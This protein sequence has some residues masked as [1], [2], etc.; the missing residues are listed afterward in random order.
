M[1]PSL[2]WVWS[3]LPPQALD[4]LSRDITP[5]VSLGHAHYH[6]NLC[7]LCYSDEGTS[8]TCRTVCSYKVDAVHVGPIYIPQ[9]QSGMF[10]HIS[11][12]PRSLLTPTFQG[13][14]SVAL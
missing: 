14:A 2:P 7:L 10:I 4:F 8:S 1:P 5:K 13:L 6:I 12:L 9:S 3:C 11:H